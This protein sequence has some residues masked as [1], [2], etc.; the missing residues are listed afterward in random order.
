MAITSAPDAEPLLSVLIPVFNEL[1]TIARILAAV[2]AVD[3]PMEIIVVDDFSTDGTR[4]RLMELSRDAPT[5]R[6][7]YHNRNQGK[8]AA[9]RT[10]I[11]KATGKFVVVQD[12]D[13]EYDPREY[14]KLL[15][16]LIDGQADVVFGS[17][18]SS[19]DCDRVFYSWQSLGNRFLTTLS[20]IC[21]KLKLTDIE[22][23]QKVFRRDII[24][25]ITIEEDGFGFEPEITA[26]ISRYREAGKPLRIYE[27]G[28][29]YN[30][31]SYEEGKK[32]GWKDGLRAIWCILKYN[33]R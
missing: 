12:A 26:K 25:N 16:P 14:P 1:P 2:R 17:R 10:A 6:V 20:N 15:K 7:L 30:G 32:I 29:S 31:R 24:Q 33:W 13:L 21:T 11:A 9:L 18:F 3:L 8:G 19:S 28:V 23:C 22:T 27:V 4:E 5:L